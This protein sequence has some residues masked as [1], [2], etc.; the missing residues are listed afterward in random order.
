VRSIVVDS[1][2]LVALFDRSDRHYA[3]ITKTLKAAGHALLLT[4]WPCVTEATHLLDRIDLQLGLL[5]YIHRGFVSVSEFT[6]AD[7]EH[8][9][10]WMAK[11]RD[12]PMD[13]ADASLVWLAAE[14]GVTEV[15][16][17]DRSDFETYRLPRGKRFR[18]L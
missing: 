10:A 2:A 5:T 13:F 1:G 17:T 6:A 8:F 3:P 15:L 7:L 11:Y 9:M 16:T 18:L 14:T 12:H 4:T